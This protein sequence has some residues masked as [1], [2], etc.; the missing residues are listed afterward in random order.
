[1]CQDYSTKKVVNYLETESGEYKLLCLAKD[2]YSTKMF[3]TRAVINFKIKKYKELLIKN[4]TSDL[5]S[6]QLTETPINLNA[7][8]IGGREVLYRYIINGSYREDSG[9]I[10]NNTY[11]WKSKMPGKYKITLWVKD[12][13]FEGTYEAAESFDFIIDEKSEEPVID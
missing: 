3:D 7:E 13:S 1:M 6:P 2:M 9:Y 12:K 5:N 10:R 4:F 11:V 8:V